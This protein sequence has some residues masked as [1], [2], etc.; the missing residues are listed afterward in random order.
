MSL[1][2]Y[3]HFPDLQL[4]S[5]YQRADNQAQ[6]LIILDK[7]SN[8]VV[9]LNQAA[10]AQGIT[11]GMGLGTAASLCHSVSVKEYDEQIEARLLKRIAHWLYSKTADISLY[12]P[13]G[14]LLRISNML[15]LYQDLT[16]YWQALSQHLDILGVDYDYACAYSPYGARLLARQKL[17]QI[18]DDKAWLFEQIKQQALQ[19]GDL[20]T[21]VVSRLQKVGVT[22][23]ADLLDLTLTELSKRFDVEVVN[24]I[25]RIT[26][27]LQ[28]PVN[29]YIPPERFEHYLELY[30]EIAN[31]QYLAKPLLKQLQLLEKYLRLKDKLA[32]EL[33]LHLHQRDCD[34]LVLTISALQGEYKADKW[35]A[36]IEL[37]LASQT[38][39]APIIGLTLKA[40]RLVDKNNQCRDLFLGAQGQVSEQEL[41]ATLIAKLGQDRVK[42]LSL[43]QDPR[44]E[45]ANGLCQ[46][47]S[48]LSNT[49]HFEISSKKLRPTLLLPKPLPL[50]ESV[51]VMSTPERIVAGWWDD[52][53]VVRDY[54]IARSD[55]GR[56]LWLFRDHKQQWFVHGL[57]S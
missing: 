29:F 24:Y 20:N 35:L 44:P 16:Q 42:G 47:F 38:L 45:V 49:Q 17:N 22:H 7:K 25:G 36:L 54:F 30:F 31:Q 26:G 52:Y 57:F 14:L 11:H 56:W 27:Q 37:N 8:E 40:K 4:C 9:Q 53:Q 12:S 33:V 18:S 39:A 21:K 1:W 50:Q 28:H 23:F 41:T 46:P 2:L 32:T 10:R 19:H 51:K 13:N 3:L 43:K 5:I 48:S 6:P 15:A 55:D 34:D